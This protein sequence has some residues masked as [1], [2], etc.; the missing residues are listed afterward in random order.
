MD[1]TQYGSEKSTTIENTGD[2]TE[3]QDTWL[4]KNMKMNRIKVPDPASA[5]HT[6]QLR[7]IQLA[8]ATIAETLGQVIDQ[9]A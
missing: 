6:D 8:I 1:S 3:K 4:E 5:S 9:Q 2:L 7:E